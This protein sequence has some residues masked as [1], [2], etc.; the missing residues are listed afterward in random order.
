MDPKNYIGICEH[1]DYVFQ[2]VEGGIIKGFE[3]YYYVE[4]VDGC[5]GLQNSAW[6]HSVKLENG[7][8]Y[9]TGD[10]AVKVKKLPKDIEGLYEI[11][12]I[13]CDK[14]GDLHDSEQ[15]GSAT[16]IV[17]GNGSVYCKGCI[18]PEDLLI[19][20]LEPADLFKARDAEGISLKGFEEVD[21]LFCDSSGFGSP[22]ERALT[23]DQA[24][25]RIEEILAASNETLYAGITGIGQFQ[26]Y[27]TIYRKVLK[28]KRKSA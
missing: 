8:P 3:F 21:T 26:V 18:D 19:E 13:G 16:F 7:K 25:A 10:K 9:K 17:V 28:K 6:T 24:E 5:K 12:T 22:G 4:T 1:G 23:R 14:C 27:V 15:Y 20:L 2:K 11:N